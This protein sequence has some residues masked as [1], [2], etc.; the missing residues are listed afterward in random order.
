MEAEEEP[1]PTKSYD[2]TP[3][4]K[5]QSSYVND[6]SLDGPQSDYQRDLDK[7]KE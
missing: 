7:Q 4:S 3:K 2:P 5:Q 1:E 6:P